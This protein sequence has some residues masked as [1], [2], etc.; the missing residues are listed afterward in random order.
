MLE[1]WMSATSASLSDNSWLGFHLVSGNDKLT[2]ISNAAQYLAHRSIMEQ[3]NVKDRKK[4]THR[5][6]VHGSQFAQACGASVEAI[7]Q[8]GNW[9]LNR[10]ST[11]YLSR[12][13]AG[14]ALHMAGFNPPNERLWLLRN[15]VIPPVELQRQVFPF[16]E[17]Q[18]PGDEDWKA[19]IENIMLDRDVYHGRMIHPMRT[20]KTPFARR[21]RQSAGTRGTDAGASDDDHNNNSD[22]DDDNDNGDDEEDDEED[23]TIAKRRHL[24]LLAH[25][26]KVVLQD[27]AVLMELGNQDEHCRYHYHH[28]F[29][30]D[31]F[32]TQLFI[33]FRAKL[34][35]DML[36]AT[37]PIT[38]SLAANA[39]GIHSHLRSVES[40][41]ADL[42]LVMEAELGNARSAREARERAVH[43]LAATHGKI[44]NAC[45]IDLRREIRSLR[46]EA[47]TNSK[48]IKQ[49]IGRIA[50][51]VNA[52]IAEEISH[53]AVQSAHQP[54]I[55]EQEAIDLSLGSDEELTMD[56]DLDV[57]DPFL[58]SA[59]TSSEPTSFQETSVQ[60]E[61]HNTA[62]SAND[63]LT[64]MEQVPELEG[65]PSSSLDHTLP[66]LESI[67]SLM[68][69]IFATVSSPPKPLDMPVYTMLPRDSSVDDLWQEWFYG[70]NGNPSLLQVNQWYGA[71]W[72]RGSTKTASNANAV[73]YLFKKN[74]VHAVLRSFPPD[75]D[76][77]L[78]ERE[79]EALLSIRNRIE[80]AGSINMFAKSLPKKA[81]KRKPIGISPKTSIPQPSSRQEADDESPV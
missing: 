62:H 29:D 31:V 52:I 33:D 7:A 61:E 11:H 10:L 58:A 47:A 50:T 72:R 38:D 37:S 66:T 24:I 74:I 3:A 23:Y 51:R 12:V 68:S 30:Y 78:L 16:I 42:G 54:P 13:D 60:C 80:S 26:R 39:P 17:D 70:V 73:M 69:M 53:M 9:A 6:R 64:S 59:A 19:W 46:N 40:R 75:R 57:P 32:K 48:E 55:P 45:L 15:N 56:L 67:D 44:V 76:M 4:V 81:P 63:D 35:A 8:H 18:F 2:E 43:A 5:G 22:S 79:A 36:T 27:A 71:S 65:P 20:R 34:H 21:R 25:L 41:V 1:Y 49:V 14:V 28:V 77:P